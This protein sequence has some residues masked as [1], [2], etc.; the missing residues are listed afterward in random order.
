[1]V[2]TRQ[3]HSHTQLP[4]QLRGSIFTSAIGGKTDNCCQ[5]LL[6]LLKTFDV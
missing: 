5:Q 6:L 4:Q 2:P 1:M 3:A